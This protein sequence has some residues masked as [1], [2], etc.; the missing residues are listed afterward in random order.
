[1]PAPIR[2]LLA[3]LWPAAL[4]VALIGGLAAANRPGQSPPL[5]GAGLLA[6]EAAM[7]QVG[8]DEAKGAEW[9]GDSTVLRLADGRLRWLPPGATEPV[10]ALAGDPAALAAAT[11]D[12]AWLAAGL[13]PGATPETRRA[14]ARSLLVLRQLTRPGGAAVAA[15]QPYWAYV[16]PRDASFTAAALAAT[17]HRDEALAIL[18]FLASAQRPDG[19]W[20]ARSHP[21][22][23][24]VDD[25]RA[26]QL[27]ATGWVPWA[28]WVVADGGADRAAAAVSWP[29]VAAAARAA[30]GALGQGSD[31][32]VLPPAGPDYRERGERQPTLGTAAPLR[33]GLRAAAG[34]A[35]RL[36]HDSDARA[37]RAAADRLDAGMRARLHGPAGWRRTPSG[38]GPDASVTWLAPP[39]APAEAGVA[40]SVAAMRGA[41]ASGGG[42]VPGA[43]WAGRDPWTPATATFALAAAGLGDRATFEGILAWL[44]GHRTALG[45]FPERVARADGAPRSVA[46][47]AW[48]HALV[49]LA[50]VE[51]KDPLPVP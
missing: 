32:G 36:G 4:A 37:F 28:A 1:M 25:G 21:D 14:A 13:V 22:A 23:S 16:W 17:G 27:D 18:G 24:P 44:L 15:A 8:V 33:A 39:F 11:A 38:G 47:L 5:F 40:A 19:T 2:P 35:A 46:P 7:V 43:P 6:N 51:A 12:H 30:A 20:P 3:R 34:L 26:A 10:T 29:M 45:A 50:L 49:V 48:T 42:L 31:A 9:V 41:L